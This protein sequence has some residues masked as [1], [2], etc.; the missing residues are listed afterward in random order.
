MQN[1]E[2]GWQVESTESNGG[3]R[4]EHPG[5]LVNLETYPLNRIGSP[6]GAR[7]IA[8]C[9]ERLHRTGVC[10]LPG[11]VTDDALETMAAEA[12]A[13]EH[14]AFFCRNHHN[15]YLE[16]HDNAFPPDHP[17]RMRLYTSVGSIAYDRLPRQSA[18]R[19]LYE[20]DPL[21][22]FMGAVLGYPLIYRFADPLGALSI[23]VFREGDRHAWHFD[24]S[25]FSTTLMLQAAEEGGEYEYVPDT[26]RA[27][28]ED[29]G[30][31]QRIIDG[32]HNDIRTLP[33]NPGDLLIFSG[34]YSIH[35]ITEVSGDMSR[36]VAILCFSTL[37]GEVNS[38][39][40][41][42]LFWGRTQ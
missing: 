9:H 22:T 26:R 21:V 3:R 25:E 12:R 33:Y 18:L 23:N 20:W 16:P 31:I 11:F 14:E 1:T 17:R 15:V 29:Y 27:G 34:R 19:S 6:E 36:L 32:E 2:Q 42:T 37:P 30:L 39:E 38:E 8:E 35:R 7:L 5:S 40:V 4:R 10:L 28:N 41:R 24:E 13:A